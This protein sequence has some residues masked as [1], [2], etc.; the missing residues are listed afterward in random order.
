M[1]HPGWGD[2]LGRCAPTPADSA[3]DVASRPTRPSW[4]CPQALLPASHGRNHPTHTHAHM[5]AHTRAHFFPFACLAA[6]SQR[7]TSDL[8]EVVVEVVLVLAEFSSSLKHDDR[9]PSLKPSSL[10]SCFES[11]DARIEGRCTMPVGWGMGALAALAPHCLAS[12]EQR[13]RRRPKAP[14]SK[15]LTAAARRHLH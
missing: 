12:G 10:N 4:G 8:R 14:D 3:R 7:V 9:K 15:A 6:P 11:G 1:L 2:A 13:R 5:H